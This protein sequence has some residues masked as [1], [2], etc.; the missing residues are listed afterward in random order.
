MNITFLLGA[1]F[2]VPSELPTVDQISIKFKQPDLKE[3]ILYFSS[4][5]WAWADFANDA[6]KNNGRLNWKDLF[7]VSYTLEE[8]VR[9][10]L[11]EINAELLNYEDYFGWIQ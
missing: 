9:F 8:T 10:Y 11:K 6:E 1:G 5:E 3:K 7:E 2:S 4:M